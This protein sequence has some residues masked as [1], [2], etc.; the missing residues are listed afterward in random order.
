MSDLLTTVSVCFI[1]LGPFLL[2]AN[3][4]QLPTVP[5][6][7][8]AGI[9][10]GLFVDEELTIE[11]AQY[12][13]ALLVFTFGVRVQFTGVRTVLFDSE[14]AALGQIIVVGTLGFGFG[15]LLGIS[16]PEAIYLAIAVALSSTI[17]GTALLQTE[18]RRNL[19]SGRLA[20]SIH[21]VQ[22]LFAVLFV[23]VMGAGALALEPIAAQLGVGL[24][25]VVAAI[26]I[27]RYLFDVVGQLAGES[28]ELMIVDVVSL[29]VV[30]VGA[31]ELAGVSLVVGA[32][33][34]GLA[35][36]HDPSEYLG[37]FNGLQ[38]I[39]D[40]FVAIFFV[41]IGALMAFPTIEKILIVTGLVVLTAVVKP[42]ITTA[43]L[44]STGYGPRTATLTSLNIDQ[45]SEFALIIAIEALVIGLLTHSVFDAIILAAAV[46]MITSSLTQRYDEVIYRSLADRD[47]FPDRF[48]RLEEWS[49]VS[50]DLTD[51]VII[52]GYGRQGRQLA[53]T[54]R[55]LSRPF[56]VI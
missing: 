16:P 14:L 11:L 25:L 55:D 17:V 12:G 8:V 21:F 48:G 32:F 35:I 50:A 45:I 5:M 23:L 43:I 39:R 33:A 56:V 38:S 10:A 37:L 53:E 27:N 40:F 52:V 6:L 44:V 46:T 36:R 1:V 24:A 42:V 34:A 28:D 3:R 13:I 51:H 9:V 2:V 49:H 19:V 26:L 15:L 29:L 54:C 41:T 20:E 47:L 30:F 22:D 18:T 7:V 4:Y 31:T